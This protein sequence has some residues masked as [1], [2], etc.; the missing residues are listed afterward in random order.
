MVRDGLATLP[1]LVQLSR[2]ALRV[3]I[4]NLLIAAT[5]LVIGDLAAPALPLGVADH[6]GSTV[7][8]SFNDLRLLRP[9]AWKPA[10]DPT[11]ERPQNIR[12]GLR[13]SSRS[14]SVGRFGHTPPVQVPVK[15]P[16]RRRQRQR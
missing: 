10:P 2:Q 1:A 15:G 3:V 5:V 12:Q 13:I 4:A 14:P 6:A 7:L 16:L 9:S 11:T 8:G